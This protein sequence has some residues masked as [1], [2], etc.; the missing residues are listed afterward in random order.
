MRRRNHGQKESNACLIP[1]LCDVWPGER[2]IANTAEDPAV[3]QRM[4]DEE[5]MGASGVVTPGEGEEP[6][7]FTFD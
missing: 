5:C 3:F 1:G 2:F 6:N 7:I 4:M